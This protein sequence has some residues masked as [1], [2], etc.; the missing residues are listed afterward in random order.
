MMDEELDDDTHLCIKCRTTI[1]GLDNYVRHRKTNC[2]DPIGVINKKALDDINSYGNEEAQ[3]SGANHGN[4]VANNPND[5]TGANEKPHHTG[6]GNGIDDPEKNKEFPFPYDLG[7][8]SSGDVVSNLNENCVSTDSK[9]DTATESQLLDNYIYGLG[10]DVFFYSLEL[11]SN[12]KRGTSSPAKHGSYRKK[13]RKTNTPSVPNSLMELPNIDQL[14]K[15]IG[16]QKKHENIFGLF[17]NESMEEDDEGDVDDLDIVG[18]GKWKLG[19]NTH[20]YIPNSPQWDMRTHNW[21]I[22]ED[23][24]SDKGDNL[25]KSIEEDN[26]EHMEEEYK[27]YSPPPSHTRGKWIPGSKMIKYV[28]PSESQLDNSLS[29]E[30]WCSLC[31]RRLT[32]KL[33]YER[34]LKSNMHTKKIERNNEFDKISRVE[35]AEVPTASP[36]SN[37][38]LKRKRILCKKFSTKTIAELGKRAPS[39]SPKKTKR[40][41][42][43]YFIKC[44]VC[45]VRVRT[46]LF[47]K[48]L[49]SHFHYR[50]MSK[51]Y[52]KSIEIILNNM[53]KIVQH[54]P[55]QCQPCRFYANTQNAFLRHWNSPEHRGCVD[56]SDDGNGRPGRTDGR[57]QRFWC[58]QCKYDCDTNIDMRSHLLDFEHQQVIQI[59]NR[60]VPIIIRKRR[61][62]CCENCEQEFHYNIEL[63][64]HK[65]HCTVSYNTTSMPP[66][67]ITQDCKGSNN[68][69][70][71]ACNVHFKSR[72]SFQNHGKKYH[73]KAQ[74]FC[75]ICDMSFETTTESKQHRR[76]A[77]HKILA[78]KKGGKQEIIIKTCKICK[79]FGGKSFLCS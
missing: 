57:K 49:I 43:C 27:G 74:Y 37:L 79:E 47:G 59:I 22:P 78:A 51:N 70:C 48:H 44:S 62:L 46:H 12:S 34:H 58:S 67:T 2:S 9:L 6:Q 18:D 26:D 73:S 19:N 40:K 45:A 61:I 32:S 16:G 13:T 17:H 28:Y 5:A 41:R 65:L 33:T 3:R 42:K 35:C 76:T 56:K 69:W 24:S 23:N 11:Q 77:K 68:Y 25:N 52:D 36:D 55:F 38:P 64:K 29:E 7:G 71:S 39:V 75:S 66:E 20:K 15:F 4:I 54:S 10:A 21:I 63:Q 31:D 8:N 14:D 53:D 30:F 1:I 50:C 60:S 72:V